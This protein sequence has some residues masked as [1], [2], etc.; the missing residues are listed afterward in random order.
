MSQIRIAAAFACAA[1]VLSAL[2]AFAETERF[3]A[4]AYNPST[5]G[6]VEVLEIEIQSWTTPE[7]RQQILAA[8]QEGGSEAVVDALDEA[9]EKGFVRGQDSL[10]YKM[11]YAFEF[12]EPERRVIVMATGRPVTPLASIDG[13]KHNLTLVMLEFEKGKKKGTGQMIY[14]ADVEVIDGQLQIT[15]AAREPTR[16]TSVTPLKQKKKKEK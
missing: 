13:E 6:K 5:R 3:N 2:P 14:G 15:S 4:T 11:T 9:T 1:I 16:F 10:A 8:F 7:E 12:N